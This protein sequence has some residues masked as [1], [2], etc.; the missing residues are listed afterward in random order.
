MRCIRMYTLYGVKVGSL[1]HVCPVIAGRSIPLLSDCLQIESEGYD[2][3][4]GFP[5]DSVIGSKFDLI[6]IYDQYHWF[7]NLLKAYRTTTNGYM[8]E[9]IAFQIEKIALG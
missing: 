3:Y 2:L 9:K 8:S 7:T 5:R 4:S 1:V 6:H